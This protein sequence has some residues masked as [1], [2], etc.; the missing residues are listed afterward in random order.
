MLHARISSMGLAALGLAAGWRGRLAVPPLHHRSP[1]TENATRAIGRNG[2]KSPLH[3]SDPSAFA[4]PRWE[5]CPGPRHA[6]IRDWGELRT[7]R[8]TLGV[9]PQTLVER[10][11]L[12]HIRARGAPR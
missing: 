4:E 9:R 1:E 8:W 3:K 2:P 11:L 10:F 12:G 6:R 7:T 5:A